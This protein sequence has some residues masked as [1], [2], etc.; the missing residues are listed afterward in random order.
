MYQRNISKAGNVVLAANVEVTIA[1]AD[2]IG[3]KSLAVGQFGCNVTSVYLTGGTTTDTTI[4]FYNGANVVKTLTSANNGAGTGVNGINNTDVVRMEKNG[5]N[6]ITVVS[7]ANK[8]SGVNY[9]IGIE[10]K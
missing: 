6:K 3:S 5:I 2:G 9:A 8:A 10:A 7:T 4:K 1:I